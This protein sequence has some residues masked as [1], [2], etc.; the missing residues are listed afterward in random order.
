MLIEQIVEL[1]FRGLEPC[2]RTRTLT[3]SYFYDKTKISKESFRVHY[4]LLLK[5]CAM[6]CTLLFLLGKYQYNITNKI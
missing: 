3:T 1:E 2:G 4:Y 5:Y 6:Q